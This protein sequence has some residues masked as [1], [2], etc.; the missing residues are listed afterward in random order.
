MRKVTTINLNNNAYQIDE[1]G[2][3]T[4]RAY[5]D[6]AER[7]LA[8]N[9]DRAEILADLEQAIAD[10]C[11]LA[12]GPYKTVVSGAEIDRILKEMGPVEGGDAKA[13]AAPAG[14][15]FTGSGAAAGSTSSPGFGRRLYR[16]RE[17][18]M[19]AGVCTGLGA[20]FG[21]DVVLVRLAFVLL[22]FATGFPLLVYIVMI[23][24]VPRAETAAQM[25]AAHGQPFN[26]QELVDRV[27]KK[28]E[29]FRQG[30]RQS[31]RER[32]MAREQAWSASRGAPPAAP[33]GYAARIAGGVMTP[34]F[35]VLSA[36]WFAAMAIAL[37]A[38]WWATH[39]G[40]TVMPFGGWTLSP[41]APHWIALLAIVLVYALV[42]LPL[43]AARRASLFYANGGHAHGWANVWSGLLWLALVLITLWVAA[44]YLPWLQDQLQELGPRY[45]WH[46]GVSV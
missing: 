36:A 6:N 4:L 30:R 43:G 18:Q 3:D 35:S 10:K 38:V 21:I 16:I 5:L 44:T 9:P 29:D 28:H 42:A 8:N 45:G 24:I 41:H 17:G 39:H 37:L 31:R 40:M 46:N 22:T 23:F 13:G 19:L 34:V 20:Y 1:D 25:A 12:L 32:M 33:P 2:Y 14:D 11:R 7:A 26:A 15:A 27:K